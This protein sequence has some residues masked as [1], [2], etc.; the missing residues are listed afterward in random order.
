MTAL[1]RARRRR[2]VPN[3]RLC[4]EVLIWK[5]SSHPNILP[6]LGVSLSENPLYFRII[7][8]WMSNGNVAEY[9]GSN[10]EANRLRMVGLAI[11]S[12]RGFLLIA[13]NDLQLSE[14]ASGVTYIHELGIAHG[15]LKGVRSQVLHSP[16]SPLTFHTG[17][18]PHRLRGDCPSR[19][20]RSN[21][22]E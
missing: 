20:F 17:E 7:S 18:R 5:R 14:V 8:E 10:P 9:I 15:D 4:R 2:L 12:P 1:G 19:G 3:Q 11:D 21:G 13:P 6:L 16:F 22:P